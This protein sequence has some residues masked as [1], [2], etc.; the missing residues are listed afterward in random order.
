MVCAVCGRV[1]NR[2]EPDDGSENLWVHSTQ[3]NTPWSGEDHPAIPV[4]QSEM[5][6]I[7]RCDFCNRD[8]P[9][10][11]IP[12]LSFEYPGLPGHFSDGDWAAC[13][14]CKVLIEK[15]RWETVIRR[16]VEQ[17]QSVLP[18]EVLKAKL[19]TMYS[20]LARNITGQPYPIKRDTVG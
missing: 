13:D 8:Y 19:S 3:D 7:G 9:T 15:R 18:R 12:A 10:W 1:L 14:T 17:T 20:R 5:E 4:P 11:V 6:G 16:A 2:F